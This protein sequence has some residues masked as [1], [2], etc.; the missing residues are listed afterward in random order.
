MSL[1]TTEQGGALSTFGRD[2]GY[3]GQLLNKFFT[4]S[5]VG[6]SI[7]DAVERLHIPLP[8]YIKMNVD[9]IEHLILKGGAAVLKNVK[10]ILI[11]INDE[12]EEQKV[13]S[14]RYLLE[15]GLI[16]KEKCHA[17]MFENTVHQHTYNQTWHRV[18]TP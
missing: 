9:G 12:F 11:E 1:T 6:L 14:E 4:F 8:D 17:D 7:V 18:L 5:T 13:S 15:A 16:L 2:Y 10:S 3:N